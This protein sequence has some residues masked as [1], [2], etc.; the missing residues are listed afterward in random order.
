MQLLIFSKLVCQ[1]VYINESR[2][3]Y[4]FREYTSQGVNTIL[5]FS[6]DLEDFCFL[7]FDEGGIN[8][9]TKLL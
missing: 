8:V 1:T 3:I 2:I 9:F 4:H 6:V 7:S 5:K